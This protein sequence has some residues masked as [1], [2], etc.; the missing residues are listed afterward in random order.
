MEKILRD[1]T[2][3]HFINQ[4]FVLYGDWACFDGYR[5]V[6]V[7]NSLGGSGEDMGIRDGMNINDKC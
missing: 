7:R 3:A 5:D 4:N 2:I 1:F 6:F